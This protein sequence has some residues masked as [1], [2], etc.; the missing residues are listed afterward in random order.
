[1]TDRHGRYPRNE[2][3]TVRI[4]KDIYEDLKVISEVTGEPVM[5][6]L[7]RGIQL[8]KLEAMVKLNNG[9]LFV[10]P[11]SGQDAIAIK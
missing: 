11:E 9:Q 8:G 3:Y 2:G 4:T 10:Q 1:M 5:K 7:H 6:I